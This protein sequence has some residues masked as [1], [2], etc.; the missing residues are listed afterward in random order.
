MRLLTLL[1]AISIGF[2]S[3]VQAQVA[4]ECSPPDSASGVAVVHVRVIEAESQVPLRFVQLRLFDSEGAELLEGFSGSGGTFSFCTV[5]AGLVELTGQMGQL[6][7]RIGPLRLV[8]GQSASLVLELREATEGQNTGTLTGAVVEAESGEPVEGAAV[9]IPDLGQTVITN[10]FGRFTFPSLP[11]GEITIRASRL[12][13]APTTGTVEV[14]YARTTHTE[15]VLSTEPIALAP[16]EVTAVRRRIVLPGMEDIERRVHSGWGKFVLEEE[17]QR[18]MPLRLT[19]LLRERGVE[20]R[21]SGRSIYMRRTGCAPVVYIDDVKVT[22]GSRSRGGLAGKP[23]QTASSAALN[24]IQQ[25]HIPLPKLEGPA[26]RAADAVNNLVHPMDV[27]AVEV[28]RGP[29]EIPGQYLD[30][31]AQ[32][33]VILIWTRRGNIGG[34]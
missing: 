32:C 17:I 8:P 12:G 14:L 34:R 6:G 28:Y 33:G 11:P 24:K 20:V 10:A 16:I 13:Y 15:V 29:A 23:S 21:D 31:N 25:L 3:H 5:P 18:R 7:G 30:S 27:V 19:Y 26:V 4:S 22:H 9:L 2:G 1:F